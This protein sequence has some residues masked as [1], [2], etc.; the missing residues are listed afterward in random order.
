MKPRKNTLLIM[1]LGLLLVAFAAAAIGQTPAQGDQKAKTEACCAM[2]SCCCN[3]G[4]CPMKEGT[5]NAEAKDASCCCN[6]DSCEMQ[7]KDG[8][9]H[10]NHAGCCGDSCK[11]KHDAKGDGAKDSCCKMKHKEKTKQKAA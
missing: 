2:E 3:S 6:G 10:V 5:E 9:N 1:L 7:T 8:K 11:M 4:S